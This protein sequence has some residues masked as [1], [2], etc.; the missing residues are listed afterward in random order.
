M[1][2]K[3]I[4]L[5]TTILMACSAPKKCCSQTYGIEDVKKMLKFSTFYAAVNG[6][7]SLSDVDVFSVDNGLSTSTVSTPYDYNFTIGLRK[8]AR[9]GYENKA[10]TFYDGTESNYSDAATVGKVKGVEYLFEVDYKRQEG[11]DYMDQHHFIRFSSDDG[12]P[13]EL[14]V[15]FFALKVEY[16]ED[17]FADIK[18]FEASE[19]YRHRKSKNLSWNIGLTH[20]LA[21]PYGY[22]ALDEWMLD[23]G[24][25]H[26]T[27]LALQE[28]YEVNVYSNE[29]YSPAGELVATSAEVW[30]AVVIPQVL[31][32][33]T[34]K[35]RNEL[36]KLIQH[37][38]VM[39]FDYYK[40]S[41]SNWLHAWG[42]LMPWH[43]NDGSE[44]SYHNYVD[45]QW[46]DYSFGLIYG[47]KQ[48]KQLG[49]FVEGKYNKYWNREWYDFKIGMNY[50]IF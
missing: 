22:N 17:G 4:I 16:L 31:A 50:T 34:Q 13:S 35:K 2:R 48:S 20:R 44:F 45:G 43:Y 46:Y 19:R 11:V 32:D 28:G 15:N 7:T 26:Y 41:K 10:Q 25:I 6:G 5:L 42:S 39:G 33:Y 24:N 40:Y 38:L 14:C 8:I 47:I 3:L 18:Y 21:E 36:K 12:C 30:E 1:V 37:S 29:Y 23:N 9:F 49:Y 27:Y